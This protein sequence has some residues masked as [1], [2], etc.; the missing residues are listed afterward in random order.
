MH[1]D[2]DFS[3][4]HFF[5]PIT[6]KCHFG[7]LCHLATRNGRRKAFFCW[8]CLAASRITS[9]GPKIVDFPGF[10]LNTGDARSAEAKAFLATWQRSET[11]SCATWQWNFAM[12]D[13]FYEGWRSSFQWYVYSHLLSSRSGSSSLG[14]GVFPRVF[15]ASLLEQKDQGGVSLEVCFWVCFG[16]LFSQVELPSVTWLSTQKNANQNS[17]DGLQKIITSYKI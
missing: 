14:W 3:S 4:P 9:D 10:A 11:F 12:V 2:L 15:C 16:G 17:T 1:D 8:T 5:G 6:R 13:V 7:Q